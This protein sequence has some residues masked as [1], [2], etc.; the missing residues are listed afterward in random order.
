MSNDQNDIFYEHQEENRIERIY[1]R[2]EE[3]KKIF[4][5]AFKKA[6]KAVKEWKD[7]IE[8]EKRDEKNKSTR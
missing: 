1:N 6:E 4:D 5:E 3:V 7:F 2:L 8:E